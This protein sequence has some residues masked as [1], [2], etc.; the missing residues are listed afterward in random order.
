MRLL[1]LNHVFK[2]YSRGS[3]VR[4]ALCDVSLSL[5]SGEL[6]AVW[7]RRRSGRSTLLRIAANVEAP[8]SGVVRFEGRDVSARHDHPLGAGISYCRKS[9]RSDEGPLVIDQLMTSHLMR[10]ASRELAHAR[11]YAALKRAGAERCGSLRPSELDGAEL[12][13]VAI[14]RALGPKP[15][16]L[17]IDDPTIGVDLPERDAILL[18]LRSFA[19]DGITVLMSV[20][21][22]TA[23]SGADRALSLDNGALHGAVDPRLATVVPIR[24]VAGA[25]AST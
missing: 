1:E 13:R 16:L 24:R 20:S 11:A 22:T 19:D 17:V 15:K 21:E 9:F 6:V 10:G 25:Q 5:E 4:V 23:L 7:G 3:S 12:V 18:L 8:D 2:R 14:A